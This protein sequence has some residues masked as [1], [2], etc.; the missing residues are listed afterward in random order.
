MNN[1]KSDDNCQKS[2]VQKPNKTMIKTWQM[3]KKEI[4]GFYVLDNN[5]PQE[6]LEQTIEDDRRGKGRKEVTNLEIAIASD[7]QIQQMMQAAKTKSKVGINFYPNR[8]AF[9]TERQAYKQI[10]TFAGINTELI[11]DESHYSAQTL[12][13]TFVPWIVS[14]HLVIKG[15]F[16]RLASPEAIERDPVRVFG[17]LLKRLGLSHYRV[18]DS[19]NGQYMVDIGRLEN[20]RE[21]LLKRGKIPNNQTNNAYK[22]IYAPCVKPTNSV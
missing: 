1:S 20:I 10:L 13:T 21:L 3:D 16:S 7:N 2:H 9:A 6:V 17:T 11:S 4:L 12:L 15:F 19:K 8:R 14:Q 18:G 22:N 5:T